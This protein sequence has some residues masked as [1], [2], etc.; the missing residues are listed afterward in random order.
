MLKSN[1][2]VMGLSVY[3]ISEYMWKSGLVSVVEPPAFTY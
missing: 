2:T 1:C 3:E